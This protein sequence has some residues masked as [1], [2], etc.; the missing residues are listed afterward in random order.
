MLNYIDSFWLRSVSADPAL[1]IC[2]HGGKTGFFVYFC[3]SAFIKS[4]SHPHSLLWLLLKV[5]YGADIW[6]PFLQRSP[7]GSSVRTET[8]SCLFSHSWNFEPV[9][10][11]SEKWPVQPKKRHFAVSY[12]SYSWGPSTTLAKLGH[13]GDQRE[14]IRRAFSTPVASAT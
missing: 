7:M 2:E 6:L 4:L 13:E 9:Y 14:W 11:S 5:Y 10:S 1:S 8:L 12:V 3:N